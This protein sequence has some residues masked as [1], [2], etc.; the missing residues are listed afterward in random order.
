MPPDHNPRSSVI[1]ISLAVYLTSN[2]INPP[3]PS[4]SM[5]KDRLKLTFPAALR[6]KLALQAAAG[7]RQVP[8][9]D[10][11]KYASLDSE[12]L[13]GRVFHRR[14]LDG[15]D[16][17]LNRQGEGGDL[18]MARVKDQGGSNRA[19][20]QDF[21]ERSFKLCFWSRCHGI[22]PEKLYVKTWSHSPLIHISTDVQ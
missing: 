21:Q 20:S 4:R 6:T 22:S 1:W 11:R 17:S 12:I 7:E 13:D 9:L 10:P 8:S 14:M 5:L 2:P 18:H 15:S 16:I 3:A 19:S